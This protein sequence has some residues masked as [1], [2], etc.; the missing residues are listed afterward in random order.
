MGKQIVV[1]RGVLRRL[2][3]ITPAN[4]LDFG[5]FGRSA[6]RASEKCESADCASLRGNPR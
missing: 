5:P 3:Q 6:A 2:I 1:Q 4:Q